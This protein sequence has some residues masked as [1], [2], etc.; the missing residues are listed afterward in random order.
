MTGPATNAA[1]FITIWSVLGKR[2]VIM[3]VITV[4]AGAIAAG[5]LLDWV[6]QATAGRVVSGMGTMLPPA[7]KNVSAVILLAVLAYAVLTAKK[8]S[9]LDTKEGSGE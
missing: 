4:A 1:A 3:Y 2:T 9:K 8:K 6:V 5:L 7:V